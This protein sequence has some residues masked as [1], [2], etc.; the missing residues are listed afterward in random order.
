[1]RWTVHSE[2]S[3]YQDRWVHLRSAD[4]ELP[5]GDRLDHRLI[6]TAAPGAGLL[7]IDDGRALLIWR[8]RFITD[9]YGWEI[10]TG[11]IEPGEEPA[12][13]AVREAEEETGWRA[14]GPVEPLLYTQPFPGLMAC[15]D[16]LF[17]AAGATYLG[18]PADDFES[19]RV[20]WVPLA[21]VPTLIRKRHISAGSTLNAL[22]LVLALRN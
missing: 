7:V 3:L 14:V 15:E 19:D 9:T 17:R 5:N 4:V 1:M 2:R 6:H 12:A 13:A 18:P 20:D 21:E 10:P 22:L 16:H 11:M 8:H